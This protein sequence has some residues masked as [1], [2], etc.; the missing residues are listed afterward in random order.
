MS[1]HQIFATE[2]NKPISLREFL[3][4]KPKTGTLR[5]HF[6]LNES[7]LKTIAPAIP[8]TPCDPVLISH[9]DT[10]N[11][12]FIKEGYFPFNQNSKLRLEYKTGNGLEYC[13]IPSR[14]DAKDQIDSK[15]PQYKDTPFDFIPLIGFGSTLVF[16]YYIQNDVWLH[17]C[18]F[19]KSADDVCYPILTVDLSPDFEVDE[20]IFMKLIE[21]ET[22]ISAPR[23]FVAL[24][25]LQENWGKYEKYFP[26]EDQEF[27]K[28][29]KPEY[30]HPIESL[31]GFVNKEYFLNRY[32]MSDDES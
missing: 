8:S 21:D 3:L 19:N 10:P 29:L 27:S 18:C 7:S 6:P 16:S 17:F 12:D 11:L 1:Q 4:L 28:E 14:D 2:I 15:F 9:F 24:C 20:E 25:Y 22:V 31:Y 23:M 5:A 30:F 32:N 13:L 26:I